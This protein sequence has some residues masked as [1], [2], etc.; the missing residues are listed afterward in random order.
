MNDLLLI[1]VCAVAFVYGYRRSLCQGSVEINHVTTFT[2]GFLFYWITPLAVRIWAPRLDFPLANVWSSFFRPQLIAPYAIA[3]LGLYSCFVAGD[4]IALRRFNHPRESASPRVPMVALTLATGFATSLMLYSIYDFRSDLFRYA[5]PGDPKVYATRGAVTSCIV[6]MAAVA[7]LFTTARLQRPWRKLLATRYFI[8]LIVGCGLLIYLGNRLYVASI[9]LM[10]VILQT[11]FRGRLKVRTVAAGVLICTVF[12]GAVGTWRE[13]SSVKGAFFNV[14]L[15]PMLNSLSLVHH[16]RY[17]GISWTNSPTQLASDFENLIPTIL[18]PN[19]FKELK[20]PDAYRPLGGLHSFVSFDMN[21][22]MLG[23][24][25]FWFLWPMLL[26]WV[27]SRS[28]NGLFATMYIMCS[29]W[30]A[31]TFFPSTASTSRTRLV[32]A[33]SQAAKVNIS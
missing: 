32:T 5:V 26:R 30:L 31:F 29:G 22:G 11:N 17:K 1:T 7:I 18:M 10:F 20:K 24:A 8:P 33:A 14:L 25:A 6:F 23:T 15:E 4:S 9:L 19:K 13:G 21:F 28:Q 16:L 3:C 2:F 27:K 12:F